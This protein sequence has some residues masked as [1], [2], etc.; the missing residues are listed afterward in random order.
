MLKQ[1][2]CQK[3]KKSNVK[4]VLFSSKINKQTDY[5]KHLKNE[6]MK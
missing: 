2:L 4:K 5:K 1:G 3:K 6:Q